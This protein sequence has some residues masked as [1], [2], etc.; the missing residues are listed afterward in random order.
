MDEATGY[1]DIR[2]QNALHTINSPVIIGVVEA[3]RQVARRRTAD[4]SEDVLSLKESL[5]MDKLI[6]S[7]DVQCR[8]VALGYRGWHTAVSASLDRTWTS[9]R[10]HVDL[11]DK[12]YRRCT[13]GENK[14]TLDAILGYV[15][16]QT[17][18]QTLQQYLDRFHDLGLTSACVARSADRDLILLVVFDRRLDDQGRLT[19]SC[20]N[21]HLTAVPIDPSTGR[22]L[23]GMSVSHFRDEEFNEQAEIFWKVVPP[24]EVEEHLTNSDLK[25]RQLIADDTEIISSSLV[26]TAIAP[27]IGIKSWIGLDKEFSCV[28][29]SVLDQALEYDRTDQMVYKAEI[30]DCDDFGF[31]LKV[32]LASLGITG[33]VVIVDYSSEHLYVALIERPQNGK[34]ADPSNLPG[35]RFVETITDKTI[36]IGTEGYLAL[37][38]YLIR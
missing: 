8:R 4:G 33:C 6:I 11:K 9:I 31:S 12:R 37:E 25:L 3:Q 22:I 35:V 38:G 10:S 30:R 1:Q 34:P 5:I 24:R 32:G 7:T 27:L 18:S 13:S 15:G 29:S 28:S 17:P 23:G 26:S 19:T 20:V 21:S 2:E 16:S 36:E 14:S